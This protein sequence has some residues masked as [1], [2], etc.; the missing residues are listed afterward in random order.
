MVQPHLRGGYDIRL[1]IALM[2]G[3]GEHRHGAFVAADDHVAVVCIED[4]HQGVLPIG[5]DIGQ[6]RESPVLHLE[7][8]ARHG[9]GFV[10]GDVLRLGAETNENKKEQYVELFHVFY[11]KILIIK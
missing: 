8:M 9:G 5:L 6:L 1:V 4:I 2:V 3:V 10:Q 11:C 7:E